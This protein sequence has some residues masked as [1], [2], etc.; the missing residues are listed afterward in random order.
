MF[1]VGRKHLAHISILIH[2]VD[3]TQGELVLGFLAALES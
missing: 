3:R 1:A 2:A